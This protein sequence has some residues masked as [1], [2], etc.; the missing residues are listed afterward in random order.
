MIKSRRQIAPARGITLLMAFGLAVTA[1]SGCFLENKK[2]DVKKKSRADSRPS[3]EEL[4]KRALSLENEKKNMTAW[5]WGNTA[6]SIVPSVAAVVVKDNKVFFRETVRCDPTTRFPMASLTKTFTAISILQLVNRGIISFNDPISKYLHVNFE[7]AELRSAPI[8]IWHLLT[9]TSGLVEDPS[10]KQVQNNYPFVIPEQKYPT[11]FRFN[12]CNQGYN[13]LGYIVFEASGLTLGEYVTRNILVPMEMKD[14]RAPASTRGAAGIECSIDDIAKYMIML[15]N[16]GK[17]QGKKIIPGRMYRKIIEET[18]EAPK[19]RNKEYRGLCFRVWSIEDKIVSLH[20]AAHMPG[21]GG[22]MQFFPAHRCG[23]VF[24]SNPPVYDREEYYGYYYAIK[25]RLVYFCKQLMEDGFDPMNFQPDQ[26]RGKMLEL[27]AGR[28]KLYANP[29][30]GQF[31]NIE[32]HPG[33]YLIATKSYTGLRYAI[34][35]TS[36]HTFVYIYPG[37]SEKGEIFDFVIK[38]GKVVGL[39]AKEG[40]FTR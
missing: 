40:Y 10:P 6:Y 29:A 31:I 38:N 37:Q 25:S 8:T 14:S 28:Y 26:A 33:G 22:F 11:G 19:S 35:P 13:L 15:M 32:L 4:A 16:E 5:M 36:L 21:A 23:Y 7:N 3:A 9:H 20:H 24:I 12:Y 39:G 18:I 2:S 34:I 1:V 17:H 30:G 27:Y